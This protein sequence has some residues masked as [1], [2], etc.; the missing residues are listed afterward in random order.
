MS[1][2]DAHGDTSTPRHRYGDTGMK[3]DIKLD[4]DLK[5]AEAQEPDRTALA[6]KTGRTLTELRPSGIA[7]FEGERVDVVTEGEF[8]QE[9]VSVNVTETE[10]NRVVVKAADGQ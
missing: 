8:I 3:N 1:A 6:G 9:G 4:K 10:G 7:E 5:D 2:T